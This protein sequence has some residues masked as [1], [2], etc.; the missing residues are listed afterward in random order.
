MAIHPSQIETIHEVLTPT[1]DQVAWANEVI[2]AMAAAEAEGRGAVKDKNGEMI[3]LMHIKVARRM[4]ERAAGLAG[5][6]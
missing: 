1:A 3:D 5:R 2:A 4:L 6:P